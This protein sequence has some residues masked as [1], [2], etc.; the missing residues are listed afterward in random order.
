MKNRIIKPCIIGLGYVGLP[1]FLKLHKKI[2]TIGYDSN[3]LRIKELKS[4]LDRN[5]EFKK[6]DLILKKNSSITS[7]YKKTKHCNF[8]IVAVPTPVLKNNRPDLTYLKKSCETI[9]KVLKK[10]DIVF[11]ESTVYPGITEN[12]CGKILE[13]ISG[14][15]LDIDFFIGYS[16]ERINPGDKKHSIDKVVKIISANKFSTLEVGKKIYKKVVKKVVINKNIKEA[17]S[18]KVIENIQRDLNI[19]LM[20]EIYK[21]CESS[22]INFENVIN[23]ASTKW[24]FIKFN[25]GLVGGHCLPV[26]PYYYSHFAKSYGVSTEILLAGRRVNNSMFKFIFQKI[27]YELKKNGL[28]LNKSKIL[29]LG[30]SYKKNVS[31]LRN[32]YVINL[33]E[34]INKN[35]LKLDIFD[36]LI[37]KPKSMKLKLIN[38]IKLKNYDLIIN[39]VD[40]NIFKKIISEIKKKKLNYI[41]LF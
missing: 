33:A 24:N 9:G 40:H 34:L 28:K 36:P 26:D 37:L 6:K 18:A 31:D 20:N 23:L 41:K 29:L 19:G 27:K 7:D 35:S 22:R 15:K 10:N 2:N 38:R 14:L 5:Y 11:F 21:V 12:Y 16:P 32:S 1:L 39:A 17:E 13:K 30:L 4:H 25:P 8:F 3:Y